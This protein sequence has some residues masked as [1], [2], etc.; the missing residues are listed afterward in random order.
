MKHFSMATLLLL[1]M[2]S[3][4]GQHMQS[5][6]PPIPTSP[7][8]ASIMQHGEFG[9]N[10][11][12]GIPDISIPIYELNHYGYKL[13]LSLSYYPQALKPGYNYDVFGHGWGLSINSCVSRTIKSIPDELNDFKL[14]SN[15]LYQ[16]YESYKD[17]MMTNYNWEHDAF[18][19]TLP[20]GS[21]FDLILDRDYG[22]TLRYIV[23]NGRKLKIEAFK[24]THNIESFFVTDENGVKYTFDGSDTPYLGT[25]SFPQS[26]VSW[27][28]S[29]IDL[30]YA[31]GA[32]ISFEYGSTMESPETSSSD[33]GVLIKRVWRPWGPNLYESSKPYI[34]NSLGYRMRLLSAIHYGTTDILLNYQNGSPSTRNYVQD[35]Q[36]RDNG[37]LSRKISFNLSKAN[38]YGPYSS[39]NDVLAKLGRIKVM[40]AELTDSTEIYR[41]DYS[42]GYYSFGGTD[43]WGYLNG[44]GSQYGVGRLN[45]LIE[46]QPGGN[47]YPG[48]IDAT[49]VPKNQRDLSPYFNLQLTPNPYV[50][51][52]LPSEASGHGILERIK[53]PSGG[54]TEFTFENNRCLTATDYDGSYIYNKNNWREM[55]AGGFRIRKI[56]N[57]TAEQTVSDTKC[58]R[59]G[60]LHNPPMYAHSHTGLGEAVVDPNILTYATF[61]SYQ[62]P[63]SVPNMLV[64][65]S[66]GGQHESFAD[67]FSSIMDSEFG[68]DCYISAANFR[69]VLDGRAP[70]VYPE[71]TVYQGDIDNAEWTAP[72]L[73]GKTVY[74]YDAYEPRYNDTSFFE[75]PQYYGN[76]LHY[77]PY[78]FR[79]NV[80]KEKRD[81][82]YTGSGFVLKRKETNQWMA[83]Y[84]SVNN[85]IFA[86][87]YQKEFYNISTTVQEWF[88]SR[89]DNIGHSVLQGKS[90]TNYDGV[91]SVTTMESYMYNANNQLNRKM[92]HDSRNVLTETKMT[93]PELAF[94]GATS[95]VIEKM[96]ERNLISPLLKTEVFVRGEKVSGDKID[97]AEFPSGSTTVLLPSQLSKLETGP[98]GGTYALEQE[99][100]R[101]STHGNPV[102][103]VT[104]G[105]VH[106]VYL[107][108]YNDRYMVAEIKNAT[109]AEVLSALN[110]SGI[111]DLQ[112]GIF[113]PAAPNMGAVNGLRQQLPSAE[114]STYTY[115]PLVGVTTMTRPSGLTTSYVYDKFGR[116]KQVKDHNGNI[117]KETLTHYSTEQ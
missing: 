26:F 67:P 2:F 102:E 111:T 87:T 110:L 56:T 21:S 33:A 28:L 108:G 79:Y 39:G 12:T 20:D 68:W 58:F 72:T 19:V 49:A 5:L 40:D 63:T 14:E 44:N 86:N 46:N 29:R 85:H 62:I 97:Y 37:A 105:G 50:D 61:S 11:Y 32:P 24:S 74:E 78:R 93:Y 52:R 22:G 36:I 1:T 117:L 48:S 53:Y 35:I 69:R 71:V 113:E 60:R 82:L 34:Y 112:S 98:A 16:R 23:S 83:S 66:P 64:G 81:H 91:D 43:H 92:T 41:F 80:L 95:V 42:G 116:L 15:L 59:Y 7:Q 54:Y 90:V 10:Y 77:D 17:V 100:L 106:G 94:S 31:P 27:Q 115:A 18:N 38:I 9:I 88:T 101:Y 65:L 51:P 73:A 4:S 84:A 107:W 25:S 103:F 75:K 8:A 55:A 13:P 114:V 89:A 30:P 104:K 6:A 99:V 3:A 47:I 76:T 45:L 96:V 109:F 57:Y 70:V